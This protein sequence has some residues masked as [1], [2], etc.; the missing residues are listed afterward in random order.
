LEGRQ[1]D[2]YSESVRGITTLAASADGRRIVSGGY[3]GLGEVWCLDPPE[4]MA[5]FRAMNNTESVAVTADGRLA[6]FA[7]FDGAYVLDVEEEDRRVQVF[8]GHAAGVRTVAVASDGRTVV[9]GSQDR[10]AQIW[11]LQADPAPRETPDVHSRQINAVARTP[12]GGQVVSVSQDWTMRIWGGEH[13][14]LRHTGKHLG[15]AQSLVLSDDGHFALTGS[16]YWLHIWDVN[17]GEQ[18]GEI[19]LHDIDGVRSLVRTPDDR[20]FLLGSAQGDIYYFFDGEWQQLGP[21]AGGHTGEVNMLAVSPDS[22]LLASA[23]QDHTVKLWDLTG[24][25]HRV[26]DHGVQVFAVCFSTDGRTVISGADDGVIRIWDASTGDQTGALAA[27]EGWVLGLTP[28]ADNHT[29]VSVS[30]DMTLAIW[31]LRD[32]SLRVRIGLDTVLWSI[33]GLGTDDAVAVGD[34]GGG[35]QLLQLHGL[36]AT[37]VDSTMER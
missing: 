11:S 5:S 30:E 26:L 29:L 28:S 37:A 4:P 1:I 6:V 7:T 12:D 27:H 35:V 31:D 3:G 2:R 34:L 22:T 36:H 20:L 24:S 32:H 14:E 9:T 16:L 33:S 17:T 25:G 21:L 8:Y 15:W 18:V 13:G 10:T 19:R 23:S